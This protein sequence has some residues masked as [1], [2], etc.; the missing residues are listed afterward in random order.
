[1][2]LAGYTG[3]KPVKRWSLRAAY[4]GATL[5]TVLATLPVEPARAHLDVRPGIVQAGA[6]VDL[7][8]ELPRLRPGP[9]PVGLEIEAAG[10]Q[11][12]STRLVD[13]V[14]ADTLWTARVRVDSQPGT[15][16]VVLRAVYADGRSVEVDDSLVVLG[17]EEGSGFAWWLVALAA[18]AAVGLGAL[19]LVVAR[20]RAW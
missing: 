17:D 15:L 8:V 18:A 14:G 10:L 16:L 3:P 12:L 4:V 19:V 11:V 5:S 20:R 7:L 1:V 6:A 9:R 2:F 13:A